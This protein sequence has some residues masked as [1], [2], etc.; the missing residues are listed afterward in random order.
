VGCAETI[1]QVDTN[2]KRE[3]LAGDAVN[4]RLKDAGKARGLEATHALSEWA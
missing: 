2:S 1:E 4:E 3:L